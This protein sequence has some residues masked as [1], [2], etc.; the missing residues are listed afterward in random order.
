MRT[1]ILKIKISKNFVVV[2]QTKK[3][4]KRIVIFSS[5]GILLFGAASYW[6]YKQ[7]NKNTTAT[8]ASMVKANHNLLLQKLHQGK[9]LF[10][11]HE[12]Q[13]AEQLLLSCAS[14]FASF[15]A[16]KMLTDHDPKFLYLLEQYAH[17]KEEQTITSLYKMIM[18]QQANQNSVIQALNDAIV[19][20]PT[21]YNLRMMRIS[22]HSSLKNA[23]QGISHCHGIIINCS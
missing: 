14:E 16:A 6:L 7:Y 2:L 21:S 12:T 22:C 8:T 17:D 18:N 20:F 5:L 13:Q 15:E 23:E 9:E 10:L 1:I 3:K 19:I 11:R 4:M